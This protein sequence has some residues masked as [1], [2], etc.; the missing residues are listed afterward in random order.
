MYVAR[1]R[2]GID[3]RTYQLTQ[4]LPRKEQAPSGE[5]PSGALVLS[6]ARR[7]VC[8]WPLSRLSGL[9]GRRLRHLH[10]A[11]EF[12]GDDLH[13]VGL[14][15]V[16]PDRD[17][18]TDLLVD[19]GSPN[20]RVARV[21]VRFSEQIAFAFAAEVE[22]L[23]GAGRKPVGIVEHLDRDQMV[24]LASIELLR[25]R[26]FA[27]TGHEGFFGDDGCVLLQAGLVQ[28]VAIVQMGFAAGDPNVAAAFFGA[29]AEFRTQFGE[30]VFLALDAGLR[31]KKRSDRVIS[32]H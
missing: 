9:F 7:S 8:G 21:G 15:L 32:C 30:V 2:V 13:L 11:G 31:P 6:Y 22:L 19:D 28:D 17:D 1:C 12:E 24:N 10:V 26:R 4:K 14:A 23:D 20:G 25:L 3:D 16:E 18:L 27:E 5:I 29:F